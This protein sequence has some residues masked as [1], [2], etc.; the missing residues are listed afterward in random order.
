MKHFSFSQSLRSFPWKALHNWQPYMPLKT[1]G[2]TALVFDQRAGNSKCFF[3]VA[4]KMFEN[5][6][7]RHKFLL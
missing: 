2:V 6:N 7:D 4:G 5:I 3:L 1:D